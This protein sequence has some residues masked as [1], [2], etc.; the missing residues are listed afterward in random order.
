MD[1]LE[2]KTI[3]SNLIYEGV[4]LNLKKDEVLTSDNRKCFREVVVHKGG[5]VILPFLDNEHIVFTKQWR[6]CA[7]KALFELPAGKLDK[8]NEEILEAAKRELKEETGY[9]ARK[10]DYLGAIHTSPGFTNE[11]LHLFKAQELIAGET[12]FDEF[13]KLESYIFT[14]KEIKDM[15]KTGEI[16]D[17]KSICALYIASLGDCD[18]KI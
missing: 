6:Y 5:V 13:E 4:I 11:I 2:E 3:A 10:W 7:N 9:S 14:I 15:I 18:E 8:E 1:N 16:T 17:A 12:N